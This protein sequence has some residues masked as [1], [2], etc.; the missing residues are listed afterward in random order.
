[1]AVANTDNGMAS[2]KVQILL[3]VTIPYLAPK[4]LDGSNVKQA[5]YIK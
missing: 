4:C 2:V 5:I 1:M 3:T